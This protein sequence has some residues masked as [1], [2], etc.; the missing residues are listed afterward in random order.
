MKRHTH[1]HEG[2]T[3]DLARGRKRIH[4]PA[5]VVDR[6]VFEHADMSEFS[7]DLDFDEVRRI[8]CAHLAVQRGIGRCGTGQN[9]FAFR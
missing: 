8:C 1:A 3:F 5:A 9:V 6:E 2:A 7:V 4:D